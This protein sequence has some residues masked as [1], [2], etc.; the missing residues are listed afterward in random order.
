MVAAVAGIVW[1]WVLL[2]RES[3]L[4]VEG[5]LEFGSDST[6]ETCPPVLHEPEA[7]Y[8]KNTC[9]QVSGSR[10]AIALLSAI[11]TTIL[12]SVAV[13]YRRHHA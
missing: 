5:Y 8:D 4:H 1:I 9:A 11:P 7:P 13:L 12:G 3:P 6:S 2:A 10:L